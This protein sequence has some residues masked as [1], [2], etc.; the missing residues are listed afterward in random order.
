[1]LRLRSGRSRKDGLI[2]DYRSNL[3]EYAQIVDTLLEMEN[4]EIDM[5]LYEEVINYSKKTG[6]IQSQ[7]NFQK[8]SRTVESRGQA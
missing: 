1:M 6:Q 3:S 7:F 5:I 8:I 4:P 2:T